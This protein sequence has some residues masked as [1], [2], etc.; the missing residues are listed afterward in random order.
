[1][2]RTALPQSVDQTISLLDQLIQ[3]LGPTGANKNGA[4]SQFVHDVAQTVGNNGPAF[5][6]TVLALGKALQALSNEGPSITSLL[7]NAGA[8]TNEAAA[9]D[10]SS[11]PSRTTWPRPAA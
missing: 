5:H 4:L 9:N 1:M 7:D 2:K 8:F 3:A 10:R 11:S 6:T